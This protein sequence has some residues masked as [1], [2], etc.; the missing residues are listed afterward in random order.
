MWRHRWPR[1]ANKRDK[2]CLCVCD[3]KISVKPTA[4]H[5]LPIHKAVASHARRLGILPP[6]VFIGLAYATFTQRCH[7]TL[8]SWALP[9]HTRPSLPSRPSH[10]VRVF[11]LAAL[12]VYA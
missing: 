3:S 2:G 8:R 12:R 6:T 10:P 7:T 11:S 9:R 5:A 4:E 1:I